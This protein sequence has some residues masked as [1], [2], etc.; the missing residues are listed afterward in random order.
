MTSDSTHQNQLEYQ[1]ASYIREAIQKFTEK[2]GGMRRELM[3]ET[4]RGESDGEEVV[5][6]GLGSLKDLRRIEEE[7]REVHLQ[8]KEGN[9]E[10]KVSM[11]VCSA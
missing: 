6:P 5:V 9:H 11:I 2:L 4:M 10:F 7:M 3:Y 8:F 1:F